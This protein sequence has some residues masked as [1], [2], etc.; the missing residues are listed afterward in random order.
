MSLSN[1]LSI[2]L[3]IIMPVFLAILLRRRFQ[4]PWIL[5]VLGVVT[6]ILSQV[7]HIPLNNWLTDLG[8]LPENMLAGEISQ[9]QTAMV[10]GL[11]AGLCEELTR[12]VGFWFVKPWRKMEDGL[13]AALGHGG[14]ESMIFG[15]V[16]LAA[17][18]SALIPLVG[19][20]LSTMDLIPEQIQV[21]NQQIS[22]Y[23]NSDVLPFSPLLE[24]LLAI[25]L[26]SAFS[27]L[28]LDAVRHKRWDYLFAAILYHTLVDA[29]L[30]YCYDLVENPLLLLLLFGSMCVPGWFWIIYKWR[31]HAGEKTLINSAFHKQMRT[32]WLSFQKELKHQWRSKRLLV[33]LFVFALFGFTSPLIAYYIPELIGSMEEVKHLAELI[34]EPTAADAMGQYIKNLTQFGFILAILLAMGLVVGE[35]ERGTA[36]MILSK[37]MQR[38]AFILSKFSSQGIV[39]LLAFTVATMGGY[40]YTVLLFGPMNIG[41]FVWVNVLMLVW[42]LVFVSISL[43]G[44]VLGKSTAAAAGIGLGGSILVFVLGS[45]PLIN[46]IMPSALVVWANQI[47]SGAEEIVMNAGALVFSIVLIINLLIASLAVFERQEL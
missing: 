10:M 22:T 21:I 44:S 19:K 12:A 13:M 26:H 27:L 15:G 41:S 32:F 11:T 4:V 46:S 20:D 1:I 35:K 37:P 8:I 43:F 28:V 6:F 31:R 29:V 33:I 42:L 25:T 36:A 14:I 39:Y 2:S 7:V 47:G 18:V 40:Y 34:P 45:V 9:L 24:R 17:T 23:I 30:V 38:W 5:F 3:M 16:M